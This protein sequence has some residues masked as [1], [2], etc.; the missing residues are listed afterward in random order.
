MLFLH[1]FI[2]RFRHIFICID[3]FYIQIWLYLQRL[4]F[5]LQNEKFLQTP[6]YKTK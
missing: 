4:K 5:Y 2:T 3:F 6:T 1:E